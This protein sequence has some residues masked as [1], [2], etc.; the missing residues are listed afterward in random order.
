MSGEAKADTK[1]T[2]TGSWRGWWWE[3][4]WSA[5]RVGDV[6]KGD[7]LANSST[8]THVKHGPGKIRWGVLDYELPA[9]RSFIGCGNGNPHG[10]AYSSIA[11]ES[12]LIIGRNGR[13][14][15]RPYRWGEPPAEPMP[16]P[17]PLPGLDTPEND[18]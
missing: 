18:R 1:P 2:G 12:D 6:R 11:T 5:V 10:S 9:G 3:H 7:Q 4:D 14:V 15:R 8:V 17:D 16:A 13:L